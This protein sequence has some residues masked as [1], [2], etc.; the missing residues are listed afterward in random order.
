[1]LLQ[2]EVL[3]ITYRR[4]KKVF[5]GEVTPE[6]N[7]QSGDWRSE[8]VEDIPRLY[9][10]MMADESSKLGRKGSGVANGRRGTEWQWTRH[11]RGLEQEYLEC[12]LQSRLTSSQT[13]PDS[14]KNWW[15]K[16]VSRRKGRWWCCMLEGLEK[17][18]IRR[19][20]TS[21]AK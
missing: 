4:V 16:K 21:F 19:Y 6:D 3:Q 8:D 2:I 5:S 18:S 14:F 7:I 9:T 11:T 15:E 10:N 12:Q 1:M 17:K 13:E 20:K